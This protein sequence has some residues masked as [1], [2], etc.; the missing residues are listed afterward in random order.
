MDDEVAREPVAAAEPLKPQPEPVPQQ[1]EP[2][3][4]Y[5]SSRSLRPDGWHELALADG[6][7]AGGHAGLGAAVS[8]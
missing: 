5:Y 8:N 2:A 3:S 7:G 1:D 4:P 6:H